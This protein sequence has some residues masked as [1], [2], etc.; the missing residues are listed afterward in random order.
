MFCV[1]F[2]GGKISTVIDAVERA[3]AFFTFAFAEKPVKRLVRA[4]MPA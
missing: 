4:P 1:P 2:L 3:L